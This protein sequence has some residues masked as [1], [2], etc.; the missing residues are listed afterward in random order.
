M[1]PERPA[2]RGVRQRRNPSRRMQPRVSSL[3]PWVAG[4][5]YAA[6]TTA[7][8]WLAAG[9]GGEFVAMPRHGLV[10]AGDAISRM[11]NWDGYWYCRIADDGYTYD[12]GLPSSVAFFPAF[13]LLGRLV[14]A[15]TRLRT[16]AALLLVSH[17]SLAGACALTLAYVRRRFPAEADLGDW[18]VLALTLYPMGLFF[19][20]AYTESLFLLVTVAAMYGMHARWPAFVVASI[21]GLAT[22]VR[23]VGVAL[24]PAL[25]WWLWRESAGWRRFLPRAGLCVPLAVWGLAAYMIY[26]GVAF[27]DPL[28]FA[29]TQ[30]HWRARAPEYTIGEQ[31]IALATLEPFWGTYVPGDPA[32]WAR[33]ELHA[34][35][36][37]S[38]Q[39]SN[40]LFFLFCV[41]VVAIGAWKRWLNAYE[42]LAAAGMLAIP[43]V[44]QSY[45][46]YMAG[47][48]R[49]SAAVWPVY[50]VLGYVLARAPRPLAALLLAGSAGLLVLYTVL[51]AAWHR[52]F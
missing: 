25:L 52:V 46:M 45:P 40:P 22:S 39:F 50:L 49:H 30:Q 2:R 36:L 42:S 9:F 15:C 8:V 20:M 51:F 29:R 21:V 32:Y 33:H 28:A 18:V 5:A 44:L 4:I 34:N 11:A 10:T 48:A 6:L 37:L 35:P 26:L 16:D 24:A 27:D 14:T 43:Y 47:A 1:K 17:L 23:P 38:L 19:R 3:D 7:M 12:P 31:V 13:P 41:G